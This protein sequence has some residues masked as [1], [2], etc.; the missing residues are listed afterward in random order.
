MD[1]AHP[2]TKTD[3]D[4]LMNDNLD[5]YCLKTFETA[6][7]KKGKWCHRPLSLELGGRSHGSV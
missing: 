1:W 7:G 3:R 6:K 2:S 5:C 4:R